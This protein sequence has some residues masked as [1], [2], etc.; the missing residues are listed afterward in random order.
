MTPNDPSIVS[1]NAVTHYL[2]QQA[3]TDLIM[4]RF[5]KFQAAPAAGAVEPPPTTNGAVAHAPKE[6]SASI[7]AKPSATPSE[8]TSP[9]KRKAEDVDSDELSD[10]ADSPPPKKAKR[11]QREEE[12]DD[13]AYARR[14]QAELN[15]LNARPTRGGGAKRK[16]TTKK[17][18]KPKKKS[19]AKVG[20]DDDSEMDGEEK[21]EK[22]KKGGFH[23][24]PH[25]SIDTRVCANHRTETNGALG[26]P[27]RPARHNR[28]LPPA[29]RQ[30]D[31]GV[32][33]RA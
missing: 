22:E 14:L 21:P 5:D 6:Q 13:A 17:A 12:E 23:V 32:C 30:A 28:P 2:L 4:E 29:D 15:A 19:K 9:T 25:N 24:R 26:A 16:P 1:I 3:I 18:T 10:V 7:D 20:S 27:G 31:M 11:I 8:P 33:Q